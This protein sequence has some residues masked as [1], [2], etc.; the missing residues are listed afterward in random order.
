LKLEK[1]RA[2]GYLEE[3]HVHALTSF[4]IVP[5]GD[6]DVRVVYNGTK[7]GLNDCLW[8]PWFRFPTVEQHLRAV[9]PGTY[10]GDLDIGEQFHNF[11]M[12]AKLQHYA[13]VDV[14]SFFPDEFLS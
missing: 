7:S 6:R 2:R 9:T 5:K 1:V 12:H 13:G 10:L 11:V 4:F 3:G 14:S 8:A